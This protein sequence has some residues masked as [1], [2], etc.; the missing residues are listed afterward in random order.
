M[1]T[2]TTGTTK[3]ARSLY[4]T[5]DQRRNHLSDQ[6]SRAIAQNNWSDASAIEAVIL[7]IDR[8]ATRAL[9]REFRR[10]DAGL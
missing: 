1:F 7:R 10:E 4:R 8:L 6:R 3:E 9:N 5:L 2:F